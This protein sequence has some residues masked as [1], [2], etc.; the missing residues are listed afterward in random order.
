M[1]RNLSEIFR[2]ILTFALL[3]LKQSEA[4]V[5]S[6][7]APFPVLADVNSF[8]GSAQADPTVIPELGGE[9]ITPTTRPPAGPQAPQY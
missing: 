1:V 2:H 5:D 8:I 6:D 9:K 7:R 3:P 4:W